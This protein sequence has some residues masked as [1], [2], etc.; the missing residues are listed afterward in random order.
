VRIKPFTLEEFTLA[1]RMSTDTRLAFKSH[2]ITVRELRE[3]FDHIRSII[4]FPP[5][6]DEQFIN[7]LKELSE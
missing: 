5:M 2:R 6:T 1:M 4:H 3:H 7:L